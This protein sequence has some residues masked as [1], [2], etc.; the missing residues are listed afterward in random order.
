M[1]D[2]GTGLALKRGNC[3]EAFYDMCRLRYRNYLD[4][5]RDSI[6]VMDQ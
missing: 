4:R 6:S 3:Y 5:V 1:E 2:F